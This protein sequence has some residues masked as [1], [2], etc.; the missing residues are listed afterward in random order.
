M[1]R[2]PRQPAKPARKGNS[3]AATR[4]RAKA[5]PGKALAKAN[6]RK[7]G[8]V[9]EEILGPPTFRMEAEALAAGRGPVAGIDEAGRGP[10]AGPVVVA[11]VVL[12]PDRIPPGLDDSKKLTAQ[13]RAEL[14]ELIFASAEVSIVTASRERIDRDNIRNA[15]LWAM[16]RAVAALPCRPGLA[17]VDGCDTP[18][19]IGCTT[20]CVIKGDATVLSIAAASIVAKVTRDRLMIALAESCPGYGL[21]K[22]MGYSTAEHIEAVARLGPSPYHRRSFWRIA[23]AF[24]LQGE[25]D[26]D[27]AG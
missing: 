11:A 22:H 1:A 5:S 25:L 6:G 20:R 21:E 2:M 10:L 26:F 9:A 18:P 7:A 24:S 14:A 17:L 19:R 4:G 27:S 15:T 3:A 16:A 23:A 13:R 8:A 12:D